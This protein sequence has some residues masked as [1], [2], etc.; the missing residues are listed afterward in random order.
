M[1]IIHFSVPIMAHAAQQPPGWTQCWRRI[2]TE[3]VQGDTKE[4]MVLREEKWRGS[5]FWRC[6]RDMSSGHG[7]DEL[8][9]GLDGL[10]DL[11]QP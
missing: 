6:F 1:I 11:F 10:R 7:G 8:V 5:R 3:R 4:N 9:V 2:K